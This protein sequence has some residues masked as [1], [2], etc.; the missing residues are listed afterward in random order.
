M[1]RRLLMGIC[2]LCVLFS[3]ALCE[4]EAVPAAQLSS[5]D[6]RLASVQL[7]S[8]REERFDTD[9]YRYIKKADFVKNGCGP[10]AL[11]NALSVAFDIRDRDCS[12]R[13][14]LELMTL[15]ADFNRPADFGMNYKRASLL[16]EPLDPQSYPTLAGLTGSVEAMVWIPK[17]PTADKILA[18]VDA[19]DGSAVIMGRINPSQNWEELI[20]TIDGLHARSLDE[21]TLSVAV[22]SA[23]T[24]STKAPFNLGDTGHFVTITVEVG[25]FEENGTV[26]VLDSYPRAVRGEKLGD[27]YDKKY[28]FAE[29][30]FLTGFRQNYSA[31]HVTPIAVKCEPLDSVKEELAQLRAEA[32]EGRKASDAFLRYRARLAQRVTMFGTGTLIIRIR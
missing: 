7:I 29:N 3:G 31:V 20:R 14:L 23:G 11:H 9:T 25:E 16:C 2:I 18:A 32:R 30:N 10:A 22:V 24:P 6:A 17:T 1:K 5:F 13:T 15:M 8:Q 19:V 21:A 28:Y 27:I 26:Y 4:D 12:E